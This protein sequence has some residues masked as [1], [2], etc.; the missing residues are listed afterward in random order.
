MGGVGWDKPTSWGHWER[1]KKSNRL[2]AC[3]MHRDHASFPS[4]LKC[5]FK[6]KTQPIRA[7]ACLDEE[8]SPLPPPC[9]E[10]CFLLRQTY[11]YIYFTGLGGLIATP[12]LCP[13]GGTQIWALPPAVSSSRTLGGGAVVA[14]VAVGAGGEYLLTLQ[15]RKIRVQASALGAWSTS[16]E[17]Q[18]SPS[19]KW[20]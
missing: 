20:R 11:D 9:L 14:A 5:G 12:P 6:W 15:S 4:H 8:R 3:R 18:F 16:G 19:V 1:G 13:A 2:N 10:A 7:E 17:S